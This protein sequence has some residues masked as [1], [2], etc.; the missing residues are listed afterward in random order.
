MAQRAPS[1]K[2]TAGAR[3]RSTAAD[4]HD[5]S[6][7]ARLAREGLDELAKRNR[8]L[9]E[10][11]EPVDELHRRYPPEFEPDAR[12]IEYAKAHGER[13][14]D[15][16]R[17]I[18]STVMGGSFDAAGAYLGTWRDGYADWF[19][20]P[21]TYVY[22]ADRPGSTHD[23]AL[24]FK[25]EWTD[26]RPELNEWDPVAHATR[27]RDQ[28]A[29]ASKAEGTCTVRS[30]TNGDETDVQAAVG[31]LF[32]PTRPRSMFQFRA[33]A[34][35]TSWISLEADYPPGTP[36]SAIA[37]SFSYGAV[38]L[39]AQSWRASDG[40]DFRTDAIRD[41]EQW[42]YFVSTP[43]RFRAM[44]ESGVANPG[45]AGWVD[46]PADRDRVYALWV[47]LRCFSRST[48]AP[49]SLSSAIVSGRCTIPF[50]FVEH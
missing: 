32:Q 42:R 15:L 30:S 41:M 4:R 9:D 6:R 31:A 37:T 1:R 50:I 25:L 2:P 24:R 21:H 10:L 43:N 14:L 17:R 38:R 44:D 19:V 8:G 26:K 46:L 7:F 27:W 48:Y 20:A 39:V 28:V 22:V 16:S 13:Y 5:L 18:G 49:P 34:L 11:F 36:P 29:V 45:N 47:I 40:S 12:F 35:W 3:K 23:P 33:L